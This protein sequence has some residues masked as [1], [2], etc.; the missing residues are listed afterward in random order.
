MNIQHFK[1]FGRP[2][3]HEMFQLSLDGKIRGLIETVKFEEDKFCGTRIK[4]DQ[5]P[6]KSKDPGD[7]REFTLDDASYI[8]KICTCSSSCNND[9]RIYAWDGEK[10]HFVIEIEDYE[11]DFIRESPMLEDNNFLKLKEMGL[12]E[13]STVKDFN[14]KMSEILGQ[15]RRYDVSLREYILKITNDYKKRWM[16]NI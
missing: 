11:F 2:P 10:K 16:K 5:A 6:I 1:L 15:Q 13:N 14:D 7:W 4:F 9:L 8:H 12:N 3:Y